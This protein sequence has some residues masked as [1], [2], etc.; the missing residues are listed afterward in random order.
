MSG[1]TEEFGKSLLISAHKICHRREELKRFPKCLERLN[2][3]LCKWF[4]SVMS[5]SIIES[6]VKLFVP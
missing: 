2:K 5:A 3:R 4:Y 1:I 6:P